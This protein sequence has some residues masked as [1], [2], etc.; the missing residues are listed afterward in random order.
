VIFGILA[1]L[2]ISV[3]GSALASSNSPYESGFDHGYDDAQLYYPSEHY[4]NQP[5]KGPEFHTS[6]FMNGYYDGYAAYEASIAGN[7]EY[8]CSEDSD[9]CNGNIYCDLDHSGDR[10]C[11]D[12]FD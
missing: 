1:V 6:E 9:G 8:D 10:P 12:R 4:I 2:F 7:P 3:P 11:Y 5:G